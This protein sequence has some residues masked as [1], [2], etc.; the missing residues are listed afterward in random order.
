VNENIK[1]AAIIAAAII[2][3]VSINS[4]FSAYNSCVRGVMSDPDRSELGANLICARHLG[5]TT[6]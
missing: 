5:G 6:D 4:Y 2:A 3:A 1:I